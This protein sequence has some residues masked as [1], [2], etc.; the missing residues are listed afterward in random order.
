[1]TL[2]AHWVFNIIAGGGSNGGTNIVNIDLGG[3]S[4]GAVLPT[5][6]GKDVVMEVPAPTKKDSTFLGWM[7]SGGLDSSTARWGT[8]DKPNNPITEKTLCV[9]GNSSV[10]FVNLGTSIKLTAVWAENK[11]AEN[12]ATNKVGAK[13]HRGIYEYA[14]T[15]A[16]KD[17]AMGK[18][19]ITGLR[20]NDYSS[21]RVLDSISINGLKYQVA[22]IAADAFRGNSHIRQIIIGGDVGF[23]GDKA[24][25]HCR[26]LDKVIIRTTE[27]KSVGSLAFRGCRRGMEFYLQSSNF[28][29][30]KDL[31]KG[32]VPMGREFI[33]IWLIT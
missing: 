11:P 15:K 24:F 8:T 6:S 33:K 10:Y 21:I 29:D 22:G 17:G 23:I 5:A 30:Y 9:N 27:L 28:E 26:N 2:T 19:V 18:V 7:V 20:T 13:W 12:P 31:L 14:V 32:R 25:Y 3:G 4:A 1:V 16:A